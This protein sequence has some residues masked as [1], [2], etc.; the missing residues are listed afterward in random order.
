MS[1][2]G[3]RVFNPTLNLPWTPSNSPPTRSEPAIKLILSLSKRL[4]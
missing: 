1:S 2:Q 3:N 4:S